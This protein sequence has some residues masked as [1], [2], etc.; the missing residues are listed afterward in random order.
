MVEDNRPMANDYRP[1]ADCEKTSQL[2]GFADVLPMI[3]SPLHYTILLS[4][5]DQGMTSLLC[6]IHKG[7][8][9]WNICNRNEVT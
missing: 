1:M 6:D 8:V 2:I 4:L 9:T 7:Y 5:W 3:G